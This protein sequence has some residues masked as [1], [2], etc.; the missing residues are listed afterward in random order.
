M[1]ADI[2]HD[3]GP[4]P[5]VPVED[6]QWRIDSKGFK[7][8]SSPTGWVARYV[9]YLNAA[10]IARLLDEWVGPTGW[11]DMYE[12]DALA[13][14]PVLW[15]HLE[16]R[17]RSGGWVRKSDVG[18]APPPQRGEP[19]DGLRE[20]GMVSDAFKRAG[21]LKWG[22][23]RNVYDLPTLWA[24]CQVRTEQGEGA[25]PTSDLEANL[26]AQLRNRGL[27]VTRV[28]VDGTEHVGLPEPSDIRPSTGRPAGEPGG[29]QCPV[30]AAPVT[31]MRAQHD[32]DP[33]KPAWK[34]TS[35]T[36]DGGREKKDGKGRWGWASW[37][38]H[39]FDTDPVREAKR[40]VAAAARTLVGEG[41]PVRHAAAVWRDA[42][43]DH[44]FGPDDPM[45][46]TV[47]A[48]VEM[49]AGELL[50]EVSGLQADRFDSE[51]TGQ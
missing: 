42:A 2:V 16:V 18:V 14:E 21:C 6:V 24:P 20:K 17:D 44:G 29:T 33:A 5:N 23:G 46:V 50:H 31:D 19:S 30:C 4:A 26:L 1:D 8:T 15:C 37:D 3:V 41:D 22:A 40:R 48:A 13:G 28:G 35:R 10:I 27:T 11:R 47:L 34:C 9:P 32:I 43:S 7:S 38:V 36:C 12:P 45:P 39:E 25:R 49:R 51:E